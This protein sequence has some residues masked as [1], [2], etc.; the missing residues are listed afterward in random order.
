[1]RKRHDNRRPATKNANL[2]DRIEQVLGMHP[3]LREAAEALS[4]NPHVEM[5]K[6]VLGRTHGNLRVIAERCIC[7]GQVKTSA[8]G[9][10]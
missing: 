6:P 2:H 3:T 4:Q 9:G 5:G 1:M 10:A 7:D 8:R